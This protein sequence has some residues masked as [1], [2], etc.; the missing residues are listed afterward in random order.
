MTLE[1]ICESLCTYDARSPD[2]EMHIQCI[3]ADLTEIPEPR[4]NCKCDNC[5]YGRDKLAIEI[6]K[7]RDNH[8]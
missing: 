3:S 7:Y 1:E 8:S 5:F 2:Y 6:L 4:N